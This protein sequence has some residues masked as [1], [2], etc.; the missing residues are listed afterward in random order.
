MG[1]FII[2]SSK[3][4]LIHKMCNRRSTYRNLC[5][6]GIVDPVHVFAELRAVTVSVSVVLGHE[7][8]RVDHFM[9]KSLWK[10]KE[11]RY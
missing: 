7:Q 3:P 6:G 1:L 8:Q 2:H 4:D 9:K 11:E 5:P 10:Q